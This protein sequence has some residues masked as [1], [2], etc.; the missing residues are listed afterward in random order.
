[1]NGVDG[2]SGRDGEGLSVLMVDSESTW[3]GGEAQLRLL[4][5]GLSEVGCAVSLA[6]P[7]QSEIRRRSGDLSVEF[8]PLGIAGGVDVVSAW[9]LRSILRG[10]R[11]DVV[12]AHA[13]M[14]IA[15][16][17]LGERPRTVVSRRVDFAVA[18]NLLGALKYRRGADLYLAISS[19]VREALRAGGIGDERIRL[20]PSGIDLDKFERVRDPSYLREE[21]GVAPG[22][23]V[24]GNVAA[25]AP[26]KAQSDLLRAAEIVC[27]ERDDVRF[28]VVGEGAL[29]KRLE[30][31]ARTLGVEARVTFTGFREDVL[32]ILSMFDC[33][34]MSSYLEG[35]GTSI[36]D[37]QAMRVPVVATDTGGI[38]DVVEDRVTGLLVPP[39][40]PESLARAMLDMISDNKLKN[41]CVTEAY[42]QSRGYDYRNMVYKTLDAY[43]VLCEAPSPVKGDEDT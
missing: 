6:A 23:V 18:K 1:V 29:R 34:V 32:E 41:K 27:R 37:A 19:G 28:F 38:P 10:R 8:Y 25:L 3:R 4:M 35:L 20:V 21:F 22:T 15:C 39:R 12:H 13:V 7:A 36:M 43:R 24:V 17:A 9:R 14:S 11:F 40:D 42:R 26:H 16:A 5:K 33:F 30:A 2:R 31:L